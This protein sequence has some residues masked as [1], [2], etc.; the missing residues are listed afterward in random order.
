MSI[1]PVVERN[2]E[3]DYSPPPGWDDILSTFRA[4][5]M[6][7]VDSDIWS[8]FASCIS[9]SNI[10]PPTDDGGVQNA[11]QQTQPWEQDLTPIFLKK[12]LRDQTEE[13]QRLIEEVEC[14][15]STKSKKK[16]RVC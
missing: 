5:Y 12:N 9:S 14:F 10:P 15:I 8:R 1:T 16:R 6:P 13:T 11:L 3:R 2:A 7:R 4:T